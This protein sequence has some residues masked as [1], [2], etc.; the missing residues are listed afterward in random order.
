MDLFCRFSRTPVVFFKIPWLSVGWDSHSPIQTVLHV[1]HLSDLRLPF[2][3]YLHTHR[4]HV[5]FMGSPSVSDTWSV[6]LRTNH[7]Y[8][9]LG[10]PLLGSHESDNSSVS[11][12]RTDP[13]C[14]L[15]GNDLNMTGWLK[16]GP[17][18]T[19]NSCGHWS[20]HRRIRVCVF[21][22][23]QVEQ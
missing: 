9:L 15:V 6:V 8:S 3:W 14:V 12:K 19:P 4:F 10:P 2:V 5:K 7:T 16:F 20:W 11:T 23:V 21:R 1:I 13:C 22:T 18:S 17:V